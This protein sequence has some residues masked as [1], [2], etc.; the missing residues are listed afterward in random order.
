MSIFKSWSNFNACPGNVSTSK[1]QQKCI[2]KEYRS[3]K[4]KPTTKNDIT[5]EDIDA[6]LAAIE[7]EKQRMSKDT[8]KASSAAHNPINAL[9]QNE[10]ASFDPVPTI[11]CLYCKEGS[12]SHWRQYDEENF[13]FAEHK[14]FPTLPTICPGSGLRKDQVRLQC[15][16]CHRSVV[17][18]M[19]TGIKPQMVFPPHYHEGFGPVFVCSGSGRIVSTY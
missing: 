4:S 18:A 2:R 11:D 5:Y 14:L 9:G 13:V 15:N 6:L 17:I 7:E 12:K 19:P 1:R 16:A 10:I 8:E 3:Y